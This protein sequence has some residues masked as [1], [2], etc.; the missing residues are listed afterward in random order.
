MG[1]TRGDR[2]E[3]SLEPPAGKVFQR[4]IEAHQ[5]EPLLLGL[6]GQQP[7]EQI[8]VGLAIATGL[9]RIVLPDRQP[10]QPSGSQPLQAVL[11]SQTREV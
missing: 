9:D 8:A 4:R 3:Q 2:R 11:R 6:G 10:Q 1:K 5:A 7:I